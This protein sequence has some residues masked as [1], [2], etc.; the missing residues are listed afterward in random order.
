MA[1][2]GLR[3]MPTFPSPSLK[4]RTVRFPQY[5]FKAGI[6]NEAFPSERSA[7]VGLPSSCVPSADGVDS[8]FCAGE[9]LALEHLRSSSLCCSTPGA[10]ASVWFMLSIPSSLNRPH[11]S[12]SQAHLDFTA[13]QLIRDVFAV[14]HRLGDPRVVPGFPCPSF[15]T[16]RPLR[17]RGDRYR[18]VPALRSQRRPSSRYQ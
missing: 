18:F 4:F 12:H 6:S 2:S 16:C 5:G 15:L 13:P 9:R 7:S 10:L 17:P 3:M 8:P 14:R 11:P 1:R